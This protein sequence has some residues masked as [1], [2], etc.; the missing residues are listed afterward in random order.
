[1]AVTPQEKFDI[2]RDLIQLIVDVDRRFL[3]T[4]AF[5][6]WALANVEMLKKEALSLRAST[7]WPDQVHADNGEDMRIKNAKHVD[8]RNLK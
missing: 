6:K 3:S 1:M 8:W 7:V 4:A 5:A 2:E